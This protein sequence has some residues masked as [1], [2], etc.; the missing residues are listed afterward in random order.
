MPEPDPWLVNLY[1]LYR[2]RFTVFFVLYPVVVFIVTVA[3]LPAWVQVA[4]VLAYA[5]GYFAGMRLFGW[6]IDVDE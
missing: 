4:L 6:L 1:T 2:M 3:K 5:V